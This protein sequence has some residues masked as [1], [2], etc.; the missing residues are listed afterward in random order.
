MCRQG[1]EQLLEVEVWGE[2][3]LRLIKAPPRPRVLLVLGQVI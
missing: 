3:D 2:V 1:L